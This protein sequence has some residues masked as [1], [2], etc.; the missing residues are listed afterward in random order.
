MFK[1]DLFELKYKIDK[2]SDKTEAELQEAVLNDI[3]SKKLDRNYENYAKMIT[4]KINYILSRNNYKVIKALNKM[5]T[6][7]E[8]MEEENL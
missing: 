1:K 3:L 2:I 7:E 6:L 4:N 8:N 5:N